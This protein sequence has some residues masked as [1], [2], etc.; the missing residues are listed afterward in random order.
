MYDES[1]PQHIPHLPGED[2]RSSIIHSRS[3]E[4]RSAL[5]QPEPIHLIAYELLLQG[6]M[7]A[8]EGLTIAWLYDRGPLVPSPTS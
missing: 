1:W 3:S 2:H 8:V 6:I 4:F 7:A 5:C